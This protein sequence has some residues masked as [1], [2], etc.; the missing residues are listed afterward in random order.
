M[1]E[2]KALIAVTGNEYEQPE[3]SD[4]GELLNLLL[5]AVASAAA[6]SGNEDAADLIVS[7]ENAREQFIQFSKQFKETCGIEMDVLN[8]GSRDG[9]PIRLIAIR[10]T[11]SSGKSDE[12]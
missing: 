5:D 6:K 12:F 1:N 4:L 10:S 2:N 8:A 9:I 11:D 7:D 3:Q